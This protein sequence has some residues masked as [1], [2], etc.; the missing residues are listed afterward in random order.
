MEAVLKSS[1]NTY[2]GKLNLASD[3]RVCAEENLG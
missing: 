2:N 3:A 1:L